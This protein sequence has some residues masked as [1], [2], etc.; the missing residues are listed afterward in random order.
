MTHD[1]DDRQ[2]P[3]LRLVVNNVEKRTSRPAGDDELF[4]PVERLIEMRDEVRPEFFKSLQ[5]RPA[6]AFEMIERFLLRKG[7]PYGLDL[8]HGPLVV[9]PAGAVCPEAAEQHGEHQEEVIVYVTEDA[10]EEGLCLSLEMILPFYSDEEAVM[11][12]ALL[13]SPVFQYGALF[14]EENRQDQMLDLIYRLGFPIYP[15]ALTTRVLDR[16]FGIAAFELKEA[17]RSLAEYP[18]QT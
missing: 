18:E 13:F 16:I 4:I 2:R 1:K 11:E 3:H 14:L 9:L 15:P 6:R 8:Q 5:R 17:L 7:L 12:D 10:S